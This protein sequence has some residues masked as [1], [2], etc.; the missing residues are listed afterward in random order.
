M[1]AHH[2]GKA[3]YNG[4]HCLSHN[5]MVLQHSTASVWKVPASKTAC[6]GAVSLFIDG[7]RK[8]RQP[9]NHARPPACEHAAL[10]T[11]R[12]GRP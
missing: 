3:L 9:T 6:L 11:Q 4:T 10:P 5:A 7:L 1:E 8:P 2:A 12:D